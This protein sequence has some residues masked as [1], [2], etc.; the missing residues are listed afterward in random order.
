VHVIDLCPFF[1]FGS[2]ERFSFSKENI[3]LDLTFLDHRVDFSSTVLISKWLPSMTIYNMC[4][5]R[6]KLSNLR[7]SFL[8]LICLFFYLKFPFIHPL[9]V[10]YFFFILSYIFR[11][12]ILNFLSLCVFFHSVHLLNFG[13]FACQ[14]PFSFYF[15]Y[16][17]LSSLLCYFLFSTSLSPFSHC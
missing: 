9:T 10:S 12:I 2:D 11:H 8:W 14:F 7:D 16:S 6:R 4:S 3:T 5:Y 1:V 17:H 13:I 15:M